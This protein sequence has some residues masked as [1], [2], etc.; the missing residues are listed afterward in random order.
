MFYCHLMLS[1]IFDIL[2]S[3]VF[4]RYCLIP[5]PPIRPSPKYVIG[6]CRCI[7]LS[8][9][10]VVLMLK[11]LYRYEAGDEKATWRDRKSRRQTT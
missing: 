4:E 6:V 2:Y 10:T 1:F 9:G 8:V 7:A 11:Y 3:L 5:F